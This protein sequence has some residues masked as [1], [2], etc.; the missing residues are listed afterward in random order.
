MMAGVVHTVCGDAPNSFIQVGQWLEWCNPC[1]AEFILGFR[2]HKI[3]KNILA[4]SIIYQLL[5]EYTLYIDGLVQ[6]CSISSA[7]AMKILQ[8][9]TK[10][11]NYTTGIFTWVFVNKF[12]PWP[13]Q[14]VKMWLEWNH[15][16]MCLSNLTCLQVTAL[17]WWLSAIKT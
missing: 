9:C 14:N 13:S 5:H 10:P 4:F 11:S 3:D 15:K 12:H 2:K 8:C 1:S 17:Y 6:D 7:L 16:L